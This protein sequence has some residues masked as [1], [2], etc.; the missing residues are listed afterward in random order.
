MKLQDKAIRIINFANYREPTS[1]LYQ[2]SEILKFKDN[3]TLNNY[4]YVHNSLNRRLPTALLDKFSYLHDSHQ[5]FTRNSALQCVK[6]PT[7]RTLVYGID[8]IT[9]KSS[10]AWNYMQI[11]CSS[12]NL[13]LLSRNACKKIIKQF[14]LDS[15]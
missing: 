6:L 12:D 11:N 7:S 9:G 5:Y 3:I 2:K 1:K 15:Y 13:H 10:R 8:S 14:Y 4:L